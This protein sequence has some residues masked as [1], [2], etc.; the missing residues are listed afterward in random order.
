[1]EEHVPFSIDQDISRA[2]LR[3]LEG[4]LEKAAK[5]HVK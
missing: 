1:L 5:E 4:A 3:A 2:Q